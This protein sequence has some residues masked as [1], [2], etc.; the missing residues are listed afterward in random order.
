MENPKVARW[1]RGLMLQMEENRSQREELRRTFTPEELA[2]LP[3]VLSEVRKEYRYE[4][5]A[6]ARSAPG[7]P[8]WAAIGLFFLVILM[9]ALLK[10]WRLREFQENLTSLTSLLVIVTLLTV[11]LYFLKGL[12]ASKRRIEEKKDIS[13]MTA[14][15]RLGYY[16]RL[17][18]EEEFFN[19]WI[20]EN[21][22]VTR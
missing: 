17:S 11:F 16:A 10:G 22:A 13:R 18:I 9:A 1:K 4:W 5:S 8:A 12:F 15:E 6:E 3:A 7:W 19:K 21:Q 20:E 2:L 14:E